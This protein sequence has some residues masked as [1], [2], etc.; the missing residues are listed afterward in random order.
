MT[1]LGGRDLPRPR[2]RRRRA[3]IIIAVAVVLLAGGGAAWAVPHLFGGN[4]AE[5]AAARFARAWSGGELGS[6][7]YENAKGQK[8]TEAYDT[9]VDDLDAN[10]ARVSVQDVS[11]SDDTATATLTVRW[12]LPGGVPWHYQTK[13]GLAREDGQWLVRWRPSIVHPKLTKEARL[14]TEKKSADRATVI[15][16]KGKH[17]IKKRPVVRVGVVPGKV[18]DAG[19]LAES[20]RDVL[21]IQAKDLAKRVR[22]AG[23]NVFVQ[24]ITL[25]KKDFD[26]ITGKLRA[27]PGVAW[28]DD[29]L[30][31]AP[32]RD[33]ASALLGRVG[34][35]TAEIVKK[36]GGRYQT[37]DVAGLSGLQRH[38]DKR[39]AGTPGLSVYAVDAE[40]EAGGD[41]EGES[42]FRV[43]A[44][45]GKPVHTTI[46]ADVQRAADAAL[47]RV[48]EK[49]ALVAIDVPSGNVL[50]V[51][52]GPEAG[53]YN[54]ALRGHYPPGS[55]FKVV[56]TLALLRNGVTVDQSVNCPEYVHIQGKSFHNYQHF[57][58]GSVP[59][60]VNFAKSCNT[61]FIKLGQQLG[62]RA[63]TKAAADLGQ[64]RPYALG[65]PSFS[66]EVPPARSR[67]DKA[68][69]SIGQGRVLASPLSMATAAASIARGK[70]KAPSLVTQ[71]APK[72][73][74]GSSRSA[75]PAGAPEPLGKKA[76]TLHDLMRK[77]VTSGSGQAVA[78]VPG[79]PVAAKTGT[80]EYGNADP[81]KTHAWFIGF[82]GDIAFAVFVNN[83]DSGGHVAGPIAKRFLTHLRK[84]GGG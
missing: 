57:A 61:A 69:A 72:Q 30:P 6:V 71:P 23:D 80:A 26:P 8:V 66:G 51:A 1:D 59:F 47:D 41:S 62:D 70:Y 33:F 17:L 11:V 7:A 22:K 49:S 29:T 55:T 52:N 16:G 28:R 34:P 2:G 20:L 24:V 4:G 35:V 73:S 25:R 74:H 48:S 42:L 10:G 9:I 50:A 18:A 81:P 3:L 40:D 5:K 21:D 77:V 14:S 43:P 44:K 12:N 84:G 36:S 13:A 56:T 15:G 76:G 31:L 39:L 60:R 37:G 19:K 32:T 46:K 64:G 79:G 58:L 65:V 45:Q 38:Y 82:Q 75:S 78:D 27:L 54:R 83:G 63:L 67:V 53:G 68:A